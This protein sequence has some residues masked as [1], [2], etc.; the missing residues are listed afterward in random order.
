MVE[1][2]SDDVGLFRFIV[3]IIVRLAVFTLELLIRPIVV[4]FIGD[5]CCG[6]LFRFKFVVVVVVVVGPPPVRP[7][8]TLSIVEIIFELKMN[9]EEIAVEE[10]DWMTKSIFEKEMKSAK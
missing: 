8:A 4:G 10:S 5:C 9:T 3:F 1:F 2:V 7:E 6:W